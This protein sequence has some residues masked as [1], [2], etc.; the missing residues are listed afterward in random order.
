MKTLCA[1]FDMVPFL[2]AMFR[3]FIE[4]SASAIDAMAVVL[5][6]ST[7]VWASIRFLVHTGRHAS[8]PYERYKLILGRSLS[9]GLEF[10][11]A[12]D[13]IRTVVATPTFASIGILAAIILTRTFLSWSLIVEMEGRWPWRPATIRSPEV[14]D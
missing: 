10:L 8:N 5:I 12:A 6:L 11:V 14:S 1:L 3:P 2:A 9:L 13:V 4:I 7:F